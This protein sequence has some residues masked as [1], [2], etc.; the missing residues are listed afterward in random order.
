MAT[1]RPYGGHWSKVVPDPA[2][3]AV[4]TCST[5]PEGPGG[6]WHQVLNVDPRESLGEGIKVGVIDTGVGP[7]PCLNV[8]D[9]GAFHHGSPAS[10]GTDPDGHGTHV[11]GLIAGQASAAHHFSGVATGSAV[12]SARACDHRSKAHQGAIANALDALSDGFGADLVNISLAS[13][14]AS[15]ILREALQD[16]RDRGTLCVCAAGNSGLAVRFPAAFPEAVAVAALGQRNW[17]ATASLATLHLPASPDLHG[18]DNLYVATFSCHGPQVFCAAPGVG[19]I[20]AIPS[21]DGR[22][23]YA[24]MDGTSTASPLACGVLASRLSRDNGYKGLPHD[25]S[26]AE[27]AR[28]VLRESCMVIGLDAEYVGFGCRQM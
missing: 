4:V 27:R 9:L 2:D 1:V 6:W 12:A 21:S 10:P 11:T 7:H 23:L 17:G 16:A 5:L 13:A 8:T 18:R 22:A 26:R 24:E 20:S 25:A 15:E 19:I 3:G 28:T 14:Q